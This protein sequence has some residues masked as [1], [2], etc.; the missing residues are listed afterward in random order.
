M[1]GDAGRPSLDIGAAG[2]EF[3]ALISSCG[4][5]GAAD[6]ADTESARYVHGQSC[7]AR[8][9]SVNCEDTVEVEVMLRCILGAGKFCRLLY[10]LRTQTHQTKEDLLHFSEYLEDVARFSDQAAKCPLRISAH[11]R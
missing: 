8:I 11:D 6:R 5:Y 2:S 9:L 3:D 1:T 4:G 10:Y 7:C